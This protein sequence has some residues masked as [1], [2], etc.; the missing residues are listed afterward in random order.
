VRTPSSGYEVVD[1]FPSFQ[2]YWYHVRTRPVRRQI[3]A[4]HDEYLRSW[5]EL[6]E[7]QIA[8]YADEGV[9]WR[10]VARRRI[11]PTLPERL[12]GILQVRRN[13]LR[14]FPVAVGQC[15]EKLGLDFPVTF[16][17]HVGIGCGAGWATTFRGRRAV[18]FG[19]E[20]AA[21]LGWTDRRTT[22]RLVEH[23][24]AHLLHD[25]W[26]RRARTTRLGDHRGPWWQ[27]YEEGWAT[28]C[29]FVLGGVALHHT[30][31][32]TRDWLSWCR[33]NRS[34]LAALFLRTVA[35]HR[36][37]WR[38]FGSWKNIDGYIETGYFLGSEVVR[39]WETR[40]P[41]RQIACWNADRIRRSAAV[42]LR[43]MFVAR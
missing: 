36:P 11:F 32:H 12:S 37:T 23:E 2:R 40:S 5:P 6:A 35:A 24:I 30:T 20:N 28:R 22:V 14:A 34:R 8:S 4:W 13:L 43:R 27:L 21:D 10:S 25:E 7:K 1:T 17:L 9:D 16:V 31:A 26:R 33:A 3:E 15:Q 39:D 38:F 41:L 29:E 42:S 19:M 18:L